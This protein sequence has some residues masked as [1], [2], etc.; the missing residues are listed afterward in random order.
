VYKAAGTG[1]TEMF[2]VQAAVKTIVAP[3]KIEIK[4]LGFIQVLK[5]V[6]LIN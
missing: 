6:Y 3:S 1:E 4:K 2:L 5:S